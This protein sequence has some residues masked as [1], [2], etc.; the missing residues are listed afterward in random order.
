MPDSYAL[1]FQES[2]SPVWG[3]PQTARE[4]NINYG[5]LGRTFYVHGTLGA[6]INESEGLDLDFPLRTI[7]NALSRCT[8]S[9]NDVICVLY[10]PSAGATGEVWPININ[11]RG[12]KLIGGMGEDWADAVRI[13]RPPV[14]TAA[15]V[16]PIQVNADEVEIAGL[17]IEGIAAGGSTTGG[18]DLGATASFAKTH[19]HHCNFGWQTALQDGIRGYAGFDLPS[20]LI[21]DC[22]FNSNIT[23]DGVRLSQNATRGMIYNNIFRL[24][25]GVGVHL[26]ALCTDVYAIF[27]NA[28]RVADAAPGEA[29]TL[30]VNAT[31]CMVYNNIAMQGKVAFANIPFVD[32]SAGNN[33]WANN[34]SNILL[35]NPA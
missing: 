8:A 21:H 27:G 12:V 33:H 16:A 31:G 35:V 29:I 19:I 28:F 13:I 23:R 2:R 11:K 1:A 22:V 7:T 9:A 32:A 26:Q 25:G 24:V 10:Y 34:M 20:L 15:G 5:N 4:E 6:D 30:N 18:I 14:G 3:V 17:W